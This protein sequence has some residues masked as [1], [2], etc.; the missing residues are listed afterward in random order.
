M[1]QRNLSRTKDRVIG[2]LYISPAV[3]LRLFHLALPI[4]L[5]VSYLYFYF[6]FFSFPIIILCPPILTS[7]LIRFPRVQQASPFQFYHPL[8]LR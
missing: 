3:L 4:H 5:I 2:T 6:I 8:Q 7:S 1:D